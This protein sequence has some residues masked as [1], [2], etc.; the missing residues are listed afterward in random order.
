VFRGHRE[1]SALS[2]I[3]VRFERC[4]KAMKNMIF[5]DK[6]DESY[7]RAEN[8]LLYPNEM[9]VRFASGN[10]CKI[11]PDGNDFKN[12]FRSGYN[13]LDYGFIAS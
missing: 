12:S 11:K 2:H 8:Y 10:L 3:S 9:V 13:I 6:W 1:I 4:F 5:E 7:S